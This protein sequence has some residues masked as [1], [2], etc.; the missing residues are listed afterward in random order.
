MSSVSIVPIV[1]GQGEVRSV[2][3]LLHRL[4]A[5]F[6]HRML[7]KVAD[8]IRCHR[9]GITKEAELERI[10]E[11]AASRLE[12]PGAILL[13]LDADDD[14]PAELGPRL[15]A[16]AQQTRPDKRIRVV[17]AH[18]EYESWFLAA[19]GS[20]GGY[21]GLPQG[22]HDHEE[23]EKPRDAKGWLREQMQGSRTY[24]PPV[25]QLVLTRAFDIEAAAQHSPSFKRF[26]RVCN[27]LF[28]SFLQPDEQE[29]PTQ[30]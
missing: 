19:A 28:D 30:P 18:R 5:P 1:E 4:G 20:L 21:C 6:S 13:L 7:L 29:D 11:L 10:V 14:C 25:D 23:P 8:P 17:L 26:C 12:G 9:D 27:E 24:S 3:A 22:L 16:R 2:P 15:L